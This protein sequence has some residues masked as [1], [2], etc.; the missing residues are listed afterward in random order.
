MSFRNIKGTFDILPF[1][2]S[3]GGNNT[4]SSVAWQFV[5][6]TIRNVMER[7]DFGEIRTPAFESTELIARGVG[8]TS[9]I[10]TKEMFAF[11][12]GD[13]NYVLRP[14]MTAPVM[15]S[16]LQHRLDQRSPVQRLYYIGACFRAERP[17]K[18]RY[19]QFHQF[20]AEII[21]SSDARADAEI[22]ALTMA[23][24][25]EF[26]LKNLRLRL[27]TLGT[28]SSR[29][30]YKAKLQ[31]FLAPYQSELSDI[32]RER[33]EKNPLRI[34]DTK[35]EHEQKILADAPLLSAFLD[36]ESKAFYDQVKQY[37]TDLGISYIEDPKLVRGL[38]YY[39]HTTFEVEM[40][41]YAGALV[42]AGRYDLLA[43]DLGN[44]D[45]VPAVGFAA[46]ME[47][48]FLA[49]ADENVALPEA[50][51]PHVFLVALGD[52][53]EK[54]CFLEAQK[55]RRE[56]LHV[57]FDLKGRS[58]KAQMREADRTNAPFVAIVGE[59]E[60]TTHAVVLKNMLDSTQ[61][62]VA[63]QDLAGKL[64]PVN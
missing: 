45:A 62:T 64:R 13:T 60:L 61:E 47:R 25:A 41:G 48:L 16:Y 37:V 52:A 22:I 15:R 3:A 26:G 9:D 24:Y 57:A 31:E 34:L 11:T 42:G 54:W 20:G 5:E 32:S 19:R 4:K 36:D 50:A 58:L 43:Q 17:A 18:G 63:I 28:P 8:E 56:G 23:I 35:L 1:D 39:A 55:L 33:L 29:I 49:L 59:N 12:K 40:E 30:A 46:G 51:V 2:Y 6:K 27:N 38:D 44:R 7:Y 14:E 53:A 21:G 10:V